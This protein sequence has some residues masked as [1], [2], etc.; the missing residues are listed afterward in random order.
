MSQT[1]PRETSQTSVAA[2][3]LKPALMAAGLMAVAALLP[4]LG[5]GAALAELNS[6]LGLGGLRG[7]VMFLSLSTLLI[8]FG[9]PRQIPAFAA[10]FAF[11]PLYGGA[12]ALAAQVA[13]CAMDFLWARAVGRA[14][15]QRKFGARLAW[16]ER[17]LA[18][19]P[20]MSVLA[21][22]LMPVGNNL[23]L[24]L[25]GG[26]TNVR[27]LPFVAAS[28]VGFMPQTLVFALLGQGSLP[29]HG[30]ALWVGALMFGLS[31]MLGVAVWRRGR[32]E[33]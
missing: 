8:A 3:A 25:A 21:L 23:L 17:T 5:H 2:K 14:F 20:F 12:L 4:W 15:C 18:H 32:P 27:M 28:A 1:L 30:P 19:S 26:V 31:A 10:G 7:E 29:S 33:A 16:L 22:R 11:G 6:L 13:A 9:V 24:N